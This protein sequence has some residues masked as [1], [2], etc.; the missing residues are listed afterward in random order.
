MPSELIR[1]ITIR[2]SPEVYDRLATVA[3]E[4]RRTVSDVV[5]HALERRPIRHRRRERPHGELIRQ[6]VR[7]GNNLNQQTRLLHLLR[8]RGDLP[9]AEALLATLEEVQATLKSVSSEVRSDPL[10]DKQPD[11]PQKLPER[12]TSP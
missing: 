9:D 11:L 10:P 7:V 4:T 6:L 12:R 3:A 1:R 2:V 5:R 8:H